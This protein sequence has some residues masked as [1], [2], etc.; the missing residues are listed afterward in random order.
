MILTGYGI[1][2][3]CMP[4]YAASEKGGKLSIQ[5]A[6]CQNANFHNLSSPPKDN[7]ATQVV[8]Y[9]YVLKAQEKL[10]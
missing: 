4:Q 7:K 6:L 9:G 8:T 10:P 3:H 2:I 1:H 5:V